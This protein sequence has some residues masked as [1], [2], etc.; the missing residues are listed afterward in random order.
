MH[1]TFV[2]LIIGISILACSSG[3]PSSPE[4]STGIKDNGFEVYTAHCKMCHGK[5]GDLGMGEA[6]DLTVSVLST[7]EM[8]AMITNGKGKMIPYKDM[9]TA[10][11]IASVAEYART[12]RKPE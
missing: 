8:I 9:L 1:S 2:I 10:K 5:A 3:T 11:Q 4:P 7:E 6:K 12:L